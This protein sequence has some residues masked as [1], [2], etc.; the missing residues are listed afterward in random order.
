MARL[1]RPKSRDDFEIVIIYALS[2]EQN[3]VEALL[4]EEYETDGFSYG[5]AVGDS[6]AYTTGRLGNQHVVLVYVP[7]MGAISAAAVASNIRSSFERIR[8]GIVV[9]LCGGVPRTADGVEILLG[10][11]V[12][13]TSVIQI[14]FGRQYP[15][16][17]I[18]KDGVEDTL[19][20]ANP[21]IRAFVRKASGNL[22]RGKLEEKTSFFSAQ[23]C[24]KDEFYNSTYPGPE[25]DKLY[26]SDYRHKHQ[27]RDSCIICGDS[28]KQDD[29]V[30]EFALQSSCA[31]LGC[32]DRLLVER[33][34]IQKAM[35]LSSDG[36]PITIASEIREAQ[37]ASIHFGRIACSNQVMKSGQHRDRIAADEGVIAF[38]MESA[39]LWDYIP[40]IVVK[41]V[42]DYADSHKNKKWQ[43]YAAVT[44]AACTKALLE[45]WRTVDRSFQ[46]KLS[47]PLML[48]T[49][50]R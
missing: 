34:R 19:G 4:D 26:P 41:S 16:K 18:R 8:V 5:K 12:I 1:L 32:D 46:G 17:F 30:C 45:E 15:N 50:S 43:E 3:V 22:V 21:E 36:R 38:E 2:I 49:A 40:T 9:G 44:A 10:D 11:V 37:K 31:E 13:S 28:Q 25:N 42:C 27:K 14:D 24:R 47:F 29:E 23:I 7:G 35:G 39:S 6:N 20:R 48:G 33:N